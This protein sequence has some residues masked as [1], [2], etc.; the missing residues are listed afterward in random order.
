MVRPGKHDRM[1][2]HLMKFQGAEKKETPQTDEK[3]EYLAL[4]WD[5]DNGRLSPMKRERFE[6]LKRKYG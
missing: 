3:A 5:S 1:I 4:K 2:I 6:E